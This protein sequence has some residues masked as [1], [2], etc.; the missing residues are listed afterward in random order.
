MWSTTLYYIFYSTKL[1]LFRPKVP[2]NLFNVSRRRMINDPAALMNLVPSNAH[3]ST[4]SLQ[5]CIWTFIAPFHL[6][7][8]W[9]ARLALEGE[10]VV[11]L[12]STEPWT[13][14]SLALRFRFP[15][16]RLCNRKKGKYLTLSVVCL[17]RCNCYRW[18][19]KRHPGICT[20]EVG[21]C[22]KC[23]CHWNKNTYF[24]LIRYHELWLIYVPIN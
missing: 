1:P 24:K 9:S 4:E 22:C 19:Q 17:F 18:Q 6:T 16:Y 15:F 21:T 2:D 5:N 20:S 23:D 10:G 14:T 13:I 11:L 7:F 12:S 3:H 8:I